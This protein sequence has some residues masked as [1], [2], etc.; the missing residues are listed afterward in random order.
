VAVA[1]I[2]LGALAAIAAACGD[3]SDSGTTPPPDGGSVDTGPRADSSPNPTT[4]GGGTDATSDAGND[5]KSDADAGVVCGYVDWTAIDAGFSATGT[6]GSTSVTLAGAEVTSNAV[7]DGGST[8]FSN[9]SLYVPPIASGDL[10][11]IHGTSQPASYTLTFGAPVSGVKLYLRSFASVA[12]FPNGTT[13]TK[14]SGDDGGFTA[15]ANVV[16]GVLD[17]T[18]APG[19]DR[20]GI[21]GVSGTV[22]TMTFTVEYPGT[23]GIYVQ[24]YA[25]H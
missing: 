6:L 25:C 8:E 17:D 16:S 4:D 15:D 9:A 7:I 12:T 18:T 22:T 13:L 11:D 10:L 19:Y 3:D 1:S 23:D 24:I 21:I 20:N 14:I 2:A 5:A